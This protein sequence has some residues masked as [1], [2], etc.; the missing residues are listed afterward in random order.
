[1]TSSAMTNVEKCKKI[2]QSIQARD[3]SAMGYEAKLRH[4]ERIE[5]ARRTLEQAIEAN[6]PNQ[7]VPNPA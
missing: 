4:K 7:P 2:L 5:D 3:T 1:M 6:R